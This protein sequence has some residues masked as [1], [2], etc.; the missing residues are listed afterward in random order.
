MKTKEENLVAESIRAMN[1]AMIEDGVLQDFA[2]ELNQ[3]KNKL[4]D[5][6]LKAMELIGI[7][8]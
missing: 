4:V 7:K 5:P 3:R 1:Q 2:K 6:Y 8:D